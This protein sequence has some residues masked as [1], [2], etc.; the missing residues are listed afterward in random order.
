LWI[1]DNRRL[2]R[3]IRTLYGILAVVPGIYPGIILYVQKQ[4]EADYSFPTA[5]QC[6]N[7]PVVAPS[8]A[9]TLTANHDVS[10]V[11]MALTFDGINFIDLG[12]VS[13]LNDSR[14]VSYTGIRYV[15]PNGGLVSLP[16]GKWGLF[17]GAGNCIDADSD[18]F[19]AIAYAESNDLKNWTVYNGINNPIA[20]RPTATFPDQATGEM[21]SIP[22]TAPVVGP[23]QA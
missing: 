21:L 19:H 15:S 14:T 7:P 6:T 18:S 10:T 4:L 9:Y 3:R 13:G 5:Q 1:K 11:R 12:A 16:G 23:T 20:S 17:F 2:S 8:Y 22:A